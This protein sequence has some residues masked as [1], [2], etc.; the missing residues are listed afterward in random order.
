MILKIKVKTQHSFFIAVHTQHVLEYS[1]QTLRE[2]FYC[3]ES[4]KKK[5]SYLRQM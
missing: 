3:L 4:K 5:L 1:V 2:N